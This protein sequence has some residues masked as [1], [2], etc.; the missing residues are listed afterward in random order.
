MNDGGPAFPSPCRYRGESGMS[1]R[2]WFAGREPPKYMME[3]IRSLDDDCLAAFVGAD[4][5][6]MGLANGRKPCHPVRRANRILRL[7]WE[8]TAIAIVRGILADAMLAER[9]KGDFNDT[10]GAEAGPTD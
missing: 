2:D 8:A 5:G 9:Q 3:D 4:A 10:P 7:K 1:L 6:V